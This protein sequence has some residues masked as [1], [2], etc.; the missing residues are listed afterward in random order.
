M[1]KK[2]NQN[3]NSGAYLFIG[4]TIAII[5]FFALVVLSSNSK[6]TNEPTGNPTTAAVDGDKQ[7]VEITSK[8]GYSPRVVNAKA[9]VPTILRMKTNNS[10]DC[11]L[12]FRIPKLKISKNLPST[13]V[14]E[15]EI[16]PQAAGS[17]IVGTCS[18]GMYRFTIKYT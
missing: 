18:M 17:E 14:T 1:S 4:I 3:S 5:A 12:A 6:S 15:F 10:F 7:V 8:N 2:K 16:P 13:G 9:N 11:G